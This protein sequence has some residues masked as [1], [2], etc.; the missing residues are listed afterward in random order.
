MTDERSTTSRHAATPGLKHAG[1]LV[2]FAIVGPFVL[3]ILPV[4][5]A[6]HAWGYEPA[7][8]L[9][10]CW[11]LASIVIWTVLGALLL[12]RLKEVAD[13]NQ[14]AGAPLLSFGRDW[15]LLVISA[16]LG[17]VIHATILA[18]ASTVRLLGHPRLAFSD[19]FALAIST[20]IPLDLLAVA[21]LFGIASLAVEHRTRLAAIARAKSLERQLDDAQV[22]ALRQQ[23]QPHFLFN[24]LG[25]ATILARRGD[26]QDAARVLVLLSDLLRQVLD[27]SAKSMITVADEMGFATRYLDI[28]QVRFGDRLVASIDATPDAANETIPA[29]LLQPL[30]E[31]AITHG[32]AP[33]ETPG[34]RI[35]VR[36]HIVDNALQLE[37]ED[38][39]PGT[40]RSAGGLGLAATRTRLAASYGSRAA[41]TLA[42]P[43]SGG[44]LATIRIPLD[45]VGAPQD[46]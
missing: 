6:L 34:G 4:R 14:A 17:V 44:C 42:R 3:G 1:V 31:N 15:I 28:E 41:L 23:L 30:V 9:A 20:Y 12:G 32:I 38:N 39:G 37:V 19:L 26:G 21:G 33:R 27:T 11:Q 2:A 7:M 8:W 25:A 16:A 29:L 22:R 5:L 13:R 10:I 46:V 18:T 45:V 35:T 36:A 43:A 40:S 24:A